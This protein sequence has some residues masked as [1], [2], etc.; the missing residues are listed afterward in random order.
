MH[1]ILISGL[2]DRDLFKIAYDNYI[3]EY[4]NLIDGKKVHIAFPK[5]SKYT[6]LS[7]FSN[8][9]ARCMGYCTAKEITWNCLRK[10]M[11]IRPWEWPAETGIKLYSNFRPVMN[12][13]KNEAK[14]LPFR[15]TH[16]EYFI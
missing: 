13:A 3:Y 2:F 8:Y 1:E 9:D 12:N 7:R 6:Q 4:V 15:V 11:T 10:N 5:Y 16:P 14:I